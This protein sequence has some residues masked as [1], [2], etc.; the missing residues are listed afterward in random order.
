M[1]KHVIYNSNGNPNEAANGSTDKI[2]QVNIQLLLSSF[3]NKSF[4]C[5]YAKTWKISKQSSVLATLES[6]ISELFKTVLIAWASPGWK[7]LIEPGWKRS[8]S[9]FRTVVFLYSPLFFV[10]HLYFALWTPS[11]RNRNLSI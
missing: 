4:H 9:L 3:W 2:K 10:L 1:R 7:K 8:P 5:Q 6:W 11:E